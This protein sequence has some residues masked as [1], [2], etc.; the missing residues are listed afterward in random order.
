[1]T[2]AAPDRLPRPRTKAS[3]RPIRRLLA[4][5]RRAVPD[6]TGQARRSVSIAHAALSL[7][8]ALGIFA[9]DVLSP[10]QGAVAVLYTIVVVI[11]A[12]A[13]Q[14]RLVLLSGGL[15]ASLALAGYVLCHS[16][17]PLDS[18]AMRLGVSLLSIVVTSVLCAGQIAS[19]AERRRAD[20]RYVTIFNAAGFPIWESDWSAAYKALK[21]GGAA[22]E[23]MVRTSGALASV[24]NANQQAANLFGYSHPGEMIGGNVMQ[25]HTARAQAT[26][27]QIFA[28][29]LAGEVPVEAEAQF[30]T[31]AGGLVDVVLRVAL[32]PDDQGWER[33]LITALDVTE[34]NEA[35]QRLAASHAELV[36]MSRVTTL[37]QIAASIAHE[38]NQP[39]SAII[40]Y[41]RSGRRWLTRDTPDA[42]EVTTCLEE[43]ASNGTRAADVVARVRDLSRKADPVQVALRVDPLVSDTIA[44]L[45]RDLAASGIAL[46]VD[47]PESLPR[48]SADRV[49]LQQVLMNL[50]L[51]A[52]QAMTA[53]PTDQRDI[54]IEGRSNG[55]FVEITVSDSGSG[56]KGRDP[57]ALFSPFFTTKAEG[58]GMGL[59]ICR[60]IMEQ[61]GGT[62]VAS[63]NTGGGVTMR[64]RLPVRDKQERTAA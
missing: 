18:S 57:E 9:L 36:H 17:E 64:L 33:V 10:L 34:R 60:S 53:T 22:T 11:A 23:E 32:P 55:A 24:R 41:A 12:W 25:H 15:C 28:R 30:Q 26:Q 2:T 59:T 51:N 20:A 61:H 45:Q 48:V 29:L 58:M 5:W 39:L 37:G 56:L 16:D 1:V 44:L 8:L 47:V 7:L 35:Q 46:R 19:A 63:Q 62:L 54:A 52:Q 43:I 21:G 3:L 49:Q 38:V 40:T 4:G 31:K 42:A 6:G 14:R 27:A 50:L 13:G